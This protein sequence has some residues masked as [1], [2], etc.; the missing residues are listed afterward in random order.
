MIGATTRRGFLAA[1]AAALADP[2]TLWASGRGYAAY[3]SEP[4][5]KPPTVTVNTLASPSPG[6][7][8]V[9]T[10]TG[11][12][13]RGP[14]IL[15]DHGQVVWFRRTPDYAINFRRQ[16][17]RGKPVLT[18]WEGQV[19]KIGTS[20]GVNRIVDQHYKT[21]A[22]VAA[23]NGYKADVHEF[24]L[25]P[26]GT[27]LITVHAET[28]ADTTSVGGSPAANVL[29]SI[30]QEVDVASGRVLYEWHSLEHVPFAETY[31]P[32][33]DPFDY[34][35]V[36]SIDV[37]L[38]GNL[39][40]SARNTAAIYKLD[41]RTGEIIWRLGGRR[42]D[43]QVDPEAGF[44]YQ[45]DARTHPDGTLTVFDNGTGE[46]A[47]PARGLHL[48][49][50]LA[51]RR[52]SLLRAF[53]HPTPLLS[54]SMGNAQLL[55][56]GGM[57]VG[58]GDQPYTTEFGPAG[59]VRFDARF[60]GGAWNYRAYREPWVGL[61][62]STPVAAVTRS[63]R[64]AVLH[65]S[66]NGSTETVYWRVNA[67]RTRATLRPVKTVRKTGFETSIR[68]DGVPL[69]VTVTALDARRRALATSRLY[70]PFV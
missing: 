9:E 35:H 62:D 43:F 54:N 31:S 46:A 55:A 32:L 53:P 58:F 47:H 4:S 48:S 7:V 64:D 21:V 20:E 65:V 33:L 28:T 17:Y 34:F 68:L 63:G 51:A 3:L 49:L 38:D 41:R 25:T 13:Q 12:G 37:D 16:T 30:V 22:L 60:D 44:F 24:Q 59:D 1:A 6:Y 10:L 11:P 23:G 18:W 2:K 45:H 29:D 67:G 15:D 14:M 57:M 61:P 56:D 70:R 19:T 26:Q 27:A 52:C 39:V 36:N 42:S 69:A 40:I 50:D 8:L 5:L 66:W